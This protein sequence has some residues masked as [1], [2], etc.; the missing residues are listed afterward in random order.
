MDQEG[1]SSVSIA[2]TQPSEPG[3][4]VWFLDWSWT[5]WIFEMLTTQKSEL[6]TYL[7]SAKIFQ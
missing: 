7:S 2:R 1:E 3:Y 5:N 4:I 6:G